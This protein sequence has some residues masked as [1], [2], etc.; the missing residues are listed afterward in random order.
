MPG[1][2]YEE[3]KHCFNGVGWIHFTASD[4]VLPK[5][6]IEKKTPYGGMCQTQ[7]HA[8]A[9]CWQDPKH[10]LYE[11]ELAPLLNPQ[12][13][14]N[15]KAFGDAS[16]PSSATPKKHG[17]PVEPSCA[18]PAKVPKKAGPPKAGGDL[19]KRLMALDD[20]VADESQT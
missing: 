3:S 13:A 15:A 8:D 4:I 1:K 20:S 16:S 11:S 10:W 17:P 9:L 5:I 7:A 18:P 12:A 19:L 6:A 14:Q 2:C